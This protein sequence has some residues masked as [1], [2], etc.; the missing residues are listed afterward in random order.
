VETA[1][2]SPYVYAQG[3]VTRNGTRKLLLVNQRD[4]TFDLSIPG[5]R[6]PDGVEMGAD[7]TYV[8]QTTAFQPPILSH[9]N[10]NQFYLNG[11]AV[12]VVTITQ[13]MM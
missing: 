3:F 13:F 9:L 4:R 11:L 10:T 7:A 8:D 12:A 2:T 5:G 1:S 6:R